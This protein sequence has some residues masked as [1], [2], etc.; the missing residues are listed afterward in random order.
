MPYKLIRDRI[1]EIVQA[2][3]EVIHT[4]VANNEEYTTALRQ[5]LIEEAKEFAEKGDP[6]E[7]ADL[8]E[9][10]DAILANESFSREEIQERQMIK[11]AQRGGFTQKI[12]LELP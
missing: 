2:K 3:G 5:K 12:L 1:P 9:V 6:E 7:L 11:A 10:I 4:R 8:F